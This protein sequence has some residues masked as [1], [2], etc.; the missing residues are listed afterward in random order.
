MANT[1]I[2]VMVLTLTC[3]CTSDK[4]PTD[5]S[6][7]LKCTVMHFDLEHQHQ[8]GGDQGDVEVDTM[9][10]QHGLYYASLLV[11]TPPQEIAAIIDTGSANL[12]LVGTDCTGCGK[13]ESI[14]E[15][16]KSSTASAGTGTISLT[17]GSGFI[18]ADQYSDTVGLGCGPQTPVDFGLI[19]Q[20]KN[21]GNIL[22]LAYKAVQSGPD[23][24]V[25]WLDAMVAAGKLPDIFVIRMCGP[26]NSGSFFRVGGIGD[27]VDTS[28][29]QYTPIVQ[30]S[31]YVIN[32]LEMTADDG[33]NT[34]FGPFDTSAQHIVD[35]GTTLML[36]SSAMHDS[37]TTYLQSV[38]ESAG[39]APKIKAGFWGDN[40]TDI[41][42]RATLS[43]A[44]IAQFPNLTVTVGGVGAS[45][46]S[47][48]ISPETYLR[49]AADGSR[50]FAIRPTPGGV[51]IFGQIFLENVDAIFDRANKQV[52]FIARSG[53]PA[54]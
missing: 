16:A 39:L 54:N 50:Y 43:A 45:P 19:T 36:V 52:G 29:A 21:V 44:E 18:S 27:G 12:F 5:P 24:M 30:E 28:K 20:S 14:F 3:A 9:R 34:S 48:S 23:G 32:A 53:C 6:I 42:V 25:P 13:D 49:K 40:A 2:A 46:V 35:T 11:G 31:Y 4:S 38:V 15:P 17:Y 41:S 37:L 47:L 10:P 26:E 8:T 33:S 22:G 51:V 7:P 1:L